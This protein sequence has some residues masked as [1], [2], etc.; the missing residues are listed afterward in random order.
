MIGLQIDDAVKADTLSGL[1][2]DLTGDRL[3]RGLTGF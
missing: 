3:R 2:H 1:F